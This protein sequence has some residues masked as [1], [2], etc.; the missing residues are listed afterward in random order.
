M[1]T[2]SDPRF[3]PYTQVRASCIAHHGTMLQRAGVPYQ[4]VLFMMVMLSWH[5]D[6][7]FFTQEGV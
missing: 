5:L 6:M 1:A 4:R 3:P 7:W 2:Q